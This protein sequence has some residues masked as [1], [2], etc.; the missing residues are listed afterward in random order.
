[1]IDAT[2]RV[3]G[4]IQTERLILRHWCEDDLEPFA[5]LNAD[6]EVMRYMPAVLDR[7]GSHALASRIR[8]HFD[9]HG[10]GLWAVEVPGV[11]PFVGYIGLHFPRFN[12]PFTPCVE[13]GWRLARLYWGKGFATEGARAAL[14]VGFG[15]AGLREIVSYTT[16]GNLRS[17]AVMQR[18][19]MAHDAADD[20]DHPALPPG[21]P[22]RR[23]VL[24]RLTR[25]RWQSIRAESTHPTGGA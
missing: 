16:P 18:L 2:P 22:L 9:R 20:F 14:Q 13:V 7:A 8:E 19:G 1:M 10:F 21:H 11:T 6:P 24:Y 17:V 15:P 3:P 4:A 25:D 12:A 23:H 5:E